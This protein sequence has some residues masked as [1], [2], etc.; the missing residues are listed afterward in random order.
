MRWKQGKKLRTARTKHNRKTNNNIDK[1]KQSM[2]WEVTR[3]KHD[4]K[5]NTVISLEQDREKTK[6]DRK[7]SHNKTWEQE[8]NGRKTTSYGTEKDEQCLFSLKS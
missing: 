1:Q 2:I 5:T 3:A 4:R 7:T 6:C 8:K